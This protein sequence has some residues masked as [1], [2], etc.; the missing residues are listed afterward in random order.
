MQ[1]T[2]VR[3]ECR[4]CGAHTASDHC[5]CC[6]GTNLQAIPALLGTVSPTPRRR[7]LGRRAIP[8]L[9]R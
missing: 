9:P 3:R 1:S 7:W 5:G 4:D 6:Q 8:P 2:Y